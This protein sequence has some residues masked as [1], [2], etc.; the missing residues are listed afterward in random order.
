MKALITAALVSS[1]SSVEVPSWPATY[2][3][4]RST[5]FMPCNY[6]GYFDP[7][8]AAQWGIADFDWSNGKADWANA[9]V[10]GEIVVRLL[11]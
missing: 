7:G 1:I 11:P 10:S 2:E 6:S 9:K 8:I 3:M 5:I 4:S